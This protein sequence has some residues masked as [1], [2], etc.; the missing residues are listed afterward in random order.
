MGHVPR[1]RGLGQLLDGKEGVLDFFRA[2]AA[3]W[4]DWRVEVE[5]ITEPEP[6]LIRVRCAARPA[7]VRVSGAATET[8]FNQDWDFRSQPL[9][10]HRAARRPLGLR[11]RARA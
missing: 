3:Q 1:D 6:G 11:L 10:V 5:D 8:I 9:R 2:I 4:P 7:P